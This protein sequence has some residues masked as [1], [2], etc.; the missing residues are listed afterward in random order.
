MGLGKPHRA[1]RARG[2]V[3]R[4]GARPGSRKTRIDRI[5][6]MLALG[7]VTGG[8]E[9]GT[10]DGPGTASRTSG[11]AIP[12]GWARIPLLVPLDPS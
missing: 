6:I 4:P 11:V 9:G 8:V 5:P 1:V 10:H 12:G 7:M 3:E 2:D